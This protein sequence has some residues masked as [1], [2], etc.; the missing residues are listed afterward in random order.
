VSLRVKMEKRKPMT[1]RWMLTA[2]LLA[3]FLAACGGGGGE[4]GGATPTVSGPVTIDF[5]HTMTAANQDTLT[6]LVD[7]FNSS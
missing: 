7:R 5:W 2:V 1:A 3:A 6:S 4:K